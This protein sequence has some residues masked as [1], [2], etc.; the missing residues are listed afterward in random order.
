M[1]QQ[2]VDL[3]KTDSVLGDLTRLH[4][5]ISCRA[6]DLSLAH[7]GISGQELDDWCRAERELISRP[8][9]EL[10]QTPRQIELDAAVAGF[11]P[12]DLN[13]RVSPQDILITG[14]GRQPAEAHDGTVC[15]SE[16]NAAKLFRFVHLP[17][18]IDLDSAQAAELDDPLRPQS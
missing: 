8:A 12:K 16:L 13:V 2:K 14:S 15:L 7:E 11:D 9:I 5:E 6:Y 1:S 3:K 18:P 17:E 10:R 4:D